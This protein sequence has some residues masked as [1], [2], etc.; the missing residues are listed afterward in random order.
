[1]TRVT[2]QIWGRNLGS[3]CGEENLLEYP[4][5]K[6]ATDFLIRIL[7]RDVDITAFFLTRYLL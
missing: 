6:L 4:N 3:V 1:M 5:S 7:G 2:E